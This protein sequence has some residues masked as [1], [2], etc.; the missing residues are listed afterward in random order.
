MADKYPTERLRKLRKL[1]FETTGNR[2]VGDGLMGLIIHESSWARK[3]SGDYN[4]SGLKENDTSK[5]KLVVTK[6]VFENEKQKQQLIK[7]AQRRGGKFIRQIPGTNTIVIEDRFMNFASDEAFIKHFVGRMDTQFK[8]SYDKLK[9]GDYKGFVYGLREQKYYT[10]SASKYH[11]SLENTRYAK[12]W[13]NQFKTRTIDEAIGQVTKFPKRVVGKVKRE[14]KKI[15]RNIIGDE[16][17]KKSTKKPLVI[18]I[19]SQP[20]KNSLLQK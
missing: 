7:G 9:E 16:S 8:K 12:T 11:T 19:E 4:Y 15:I 3:T 17:A 10:D 13:L 1:L 18:K 5:G 2:G 14:G 20:K 6:E